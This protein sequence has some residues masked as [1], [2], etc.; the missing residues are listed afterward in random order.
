MEKK[1][2][3]TIMYSKNIQTNSFNKSVEDIKRFGI[4]VS[5]T[6]NIF[7]YVVFCTLSAYLKDG[8]NWRTFEPSCPAL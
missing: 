8:F 2:A 5:A 3:K 7:S 4:D 1:L 6:R